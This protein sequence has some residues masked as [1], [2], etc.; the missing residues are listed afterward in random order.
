MNKRLEILENNLLQ[1]FKS[2][3]NVN[4]NHTQNGLMTPK[5]KAITE[6]QKQLEASHE[7][8]KELANRHMVPP[9]QAVPVENK[10]TEEPKVLKGEQVFLRDSEQINVIPV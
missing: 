10:Q 7:Q 5:S 3:H 1:Q 2:V 6:I 9:P 4:V 8:L